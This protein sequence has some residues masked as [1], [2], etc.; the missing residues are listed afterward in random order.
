MTCCYQVIGCDVITSY[1]VSFERV[2]YQNLYVSSNRS[3]SFININKTDYPAQ[4]IN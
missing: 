2:D 1:Y 3:F 4:L